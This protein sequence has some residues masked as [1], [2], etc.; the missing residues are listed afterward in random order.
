MDPLDL[1][2]F[3]YCR[4]FGWSSGRTVKEA[5]GCYRTVGWLSGV[6]VGLKYT[7]WDQIQI[8][9]SQIR[10][11]LNITLPDC[12]SNANFQFKYIYTA[13]FDSNTIQVHCHFW[14][15]IQIW[16][17]YVACVSIIVQVYHSG[18]SFVFGLTDW[19]Q[20]GLLDCPY[21][22]CCTN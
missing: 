4:T 11:K 15:V 10:Y 19:L 6:R 12:N 5:F 17:K 21:L 16:F 20:A 2:M 9:L 8:K 7:F 13:I 1:S 18:W 14:D 22:Y 3:G